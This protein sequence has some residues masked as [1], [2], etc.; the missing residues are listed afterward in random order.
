M[1]KEPNKKIEYVISYPLKLAYTL[2]VISFALAIIC[3]LRSFLFLFAIQIKGIILG[4]RA[5]SDININ[6]EHYNDN[7]LVKVSLVINY[8]VIFF[9]LLLIFIFKPSVTFLLNFIVN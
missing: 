4:H 3:L 8:L 7:G 1:N 5:K 6:P 9:S 2:R